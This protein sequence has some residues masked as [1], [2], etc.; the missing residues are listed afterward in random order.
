MPVSHFKLSRQSS[1][2]STAVIR[3]VAL[4]LSLT[5]V[6]GA[7]CAK[8]FHKESRSDEQLYNQGEQLF[9]EG[10]YRKAAKTMGELLQ[11]YFESEYK[12]RALFI[13]AESQFLRGKYEDAQFNYDK[14]IE[15]HPAHRWAE[16]AYYRSALCDFNRILSYDKDQTY[17][18]RA[19]EK[20]NNF[21]AKYPGDRYKDDVKK[22]IGFARNR[23]MQHE[24]YVAD[25][26]FRTKAYNSAIGRYENILK[27]YPEG[28]SADKVLFKLGRA[29]EKTGDKQK[30]RETYRELYSRYPR[31]K[32]GKKVKNK[33]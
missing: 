19:I 31:S 2:I 3:L 14:F 17:T 7:G 10:K 15:M 20:L 12:A 27:I 6:Y 13:M 18:K 4:S 9:R 24:L 21:T 8:F 16:K 32:F 26:Y 33:L 30:A 23:L 28:T 1:R 25:F 11:E 29:Y 22:R 5:L